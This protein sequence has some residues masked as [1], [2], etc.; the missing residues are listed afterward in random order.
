[1]IRPLLPADVEAVLDLW[2][3]LMDEGAAADPRYRRLPTA[4]RVFAPYVRDV[5]TRDRP[6][7]ATWVADEGG[8]LGYVGILPQTPLPLLDRPP[9]ALITDCYVRPAH[10]GKGLGRAL[11]EGAVGA[12][13]VAGWPAV[14]VGTLTGDTRAVAFW[15]ALGFG[16]WKV[17]LIRESGA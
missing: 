13:R 15:T 1:V 9:T 14:E 16:P 11:V 4:R 6:F 12:A 10:R 3:A 17:S 8:L 7:P 2:E 5:W